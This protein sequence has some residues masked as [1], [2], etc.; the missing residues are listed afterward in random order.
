[1]RR[2][3]ATVPVG[4]LLLL[5]IQGATATAETPPDGVDALTPSAQTVTGAAG[6]EFADLRITVAQT[7]DLSSQ[8]VTVTWEWPGHET[9]PVDGF[10]VNY[11]QFMQ[12]WGEDPAH[13]DF[14][15]TCQFGVGLDAPGIGGLATNLRSIVRSVDPAETRYPADALAVPFRA[16]GGE[17]TPDGS[18]ASPFPSRP[19]T[20]GVPVDAPDTL[21]S[22][23]TPY[24]GNEVPYARTPASG[25]G[26]LVFEVQTAL[27]APHLGCGAVEASG[28]RAPRKCWLVIVPR[29]TTDA[30]GKP[31]D[32]VVNPAAGSPLTTS[33]WK[34]RI[35]VELAFAPIGGYCKLG[36]NERRTVG[37]E[38]VAQAMNSWQ[39]AQCADGGPTFGYSRTGDFE[40]GRQVASRQEGAPGLGFTPDPIVPGPD[41]P[42][43]VHA[44]VAVSGIV[45]A[46][47]IDTMVSDGPVEVVRRRG[48]PVREL[49]LNPRLMAKL[50]TQ[51]YKR[52]V[53]GGPLRCTPEAEKKDPARYCPTHVANNWTNLRAD[54]E[55]R[56][57]NPEFEHFETNR[58]PDGLMVGYGSSAA[59]REVWRW[60]L[61]DEAARRFLAGEV[62]ADP[63]G[64]NPAIA[65]VVNK[66]YRSLGIAGAA[67]PDSFPKL[68]PTCRWE[69]GESVPEPGFCTLDHRPYVNSMREGAYQTLRADAKSKR[70]WNPT[71][72]PP[73][74]DATKPMPPGL[75]W[76]MTITDSASATRYG[77]YAA[78]LQNRAG[79]FVKADTTSLLKGVAAMTHSA[80]PGVLAVDPDVKAA[81]AYPLT[82]VTYAAADL[83][84]EASA[85]HDY[86]GLL[87][88]A[89]GSGQ[90]AGTERGQLPRGYAPL[91]DALR[92][93]TRS[94]ADR[95]E[96][97]VSGGS[98]GSPDR[99][100]VAGV[101]A[102]PAQPGPGPNGPP[103]VSAR[104]SQAAT[105][106][107][108]P[109]EPVGL[110]RWAFLAVV[111]MGV[112]AAVTGGSLRV[113]ALRLRRRR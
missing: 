34:N 107:R 39:P 55:F 1:M 20:P 23:F 37:T 66:H 97:G 43:V 32:P 80:T 87:R 86:A 9:L 24:T 14:R 22:L 62:Q 71:K 50:L 100:G 40:V 41:D 64:T 61:A 3:F 63:T 113:G 68:D 77:L 28:G 105:A 75:R 5:T 60:I 49:N 36:Q 58:A 27:E 102:G 13:P 109:A 72:Q 29:G 31:L 15:E 84:E 54:P 8:G 42:P 59:A 82:M 99:A 48:T 19:G 45:V 95:L 38:L 98:D 85:R 25:V 103:R 106:R 2:W 108:T 56:M 70:V 94:A 92:A 110:I 57:L 17:R 47:N 89:A 83:T 35:A 21:A 81:G 93:Q 30:A 18:A 90:I 73:Q 26:R 96:A 104:P 11:L 101:P 88:Y 51:T 112:V 79:E 78:K 91:P 69:S 111:G 74:F 16:V 76:A 53:A 65:N 52:D 46:F 7:K 33:A 6:T 67:A 10:G 12:C 44:P 4:L